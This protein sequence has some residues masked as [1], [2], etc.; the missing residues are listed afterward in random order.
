MMKLCFSKVS[1]KIS[2]LVVV[3]QTDLDNFLHPQIYKQRLKT[4]QEASANKINLQTCTYFRGLC[5]GF[6]LC[7]TF[8]L[9]IRKKEQN[10][11]INLF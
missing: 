10:I 7:N 8:G 1:K 4:L 9:D 11:H 5:E 3:E 2:A 6:S